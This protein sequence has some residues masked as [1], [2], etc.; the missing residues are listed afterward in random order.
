[1]RWALATVIACVPMIAAAQPAEDE[2]PVWAMVQHYRGAA[3][4]S[5]VTLDAQLSAGCAAHAEYLRLNHGKPQLAGLGAHAQD[6]SLPGASA[7]GAECGANADLMLGTDD[8]VG[9]V[10]GFLAGMY[11]RRPIL[12]PTLERIGTG[13]S[14]LPDGRWIVVLRLDARSRS[15]SAKWPV[16]YPADGQRRVPSQYSAEIPR[17]RGDGYPITLQ[18]PPGDAI[19]KV[20][21]TLVA[22]GRAVPFV[23]SDPTRPATS[24]PQAG[25]VALIP[26]S[27]LAKGTVYTVTVK[28]KWRGTLRTWKWKF[29]TA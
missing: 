15:Q 11:H 4:L 22:N 16:R 12:D 9:A 20:S 19:T 24:F 3:G 28:A 1:M 17:P 2:D 27:A 13:Y 29:T 14:Q 6:P 25:I 26:T 5:E 7:A 21:A 10:D 8:I 18:F 23:L